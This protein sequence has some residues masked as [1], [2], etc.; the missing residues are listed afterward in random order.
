MTDDTGVSGTNEKTLNKLLQVYIHI[1]VIDHWPS[2][3]LFNMCR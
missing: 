1:D 3:I 2:I